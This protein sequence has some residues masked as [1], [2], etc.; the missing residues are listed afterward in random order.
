MNRDA[1]RYPQLFALCTRFIAAFHARGELNA[2]IDV[3]L[4]HEDDFMRI[5]HQ[6]NVG[7]A[8]AGVR[9]LARILTRPHG[10]STLREF[11]DT[12]FPDTPP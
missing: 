7:D 2:G 12:H 3:I 8:V 1:L 6:V 5:A 4:K 11:T 10:L 9:I